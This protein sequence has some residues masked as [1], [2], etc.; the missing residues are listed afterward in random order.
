MKTTLSL[1]AWILVRRNDEVVRVAVEAIGCPY[2][3]GLVAHPEHLGSR[4]SITHELSRL[5]VTFARSREAAMAEIRRL[6]PFADWTLDAESL[7]EDEERITA[8]VSDE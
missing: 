6:A 2:V 5:S 1:S 3:P 7:R 4:W 8:L